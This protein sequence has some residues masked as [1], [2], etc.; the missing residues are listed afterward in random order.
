MTLLVDEIELDG[1]RVLNE[2]PSGTKNGVNT[3][4]GLANDFES[5]TLQL[6]VNG[7]RKTEGVGNDFVATESGGPGT[8]FDGFTLAFPPIADDNLLADYVKAL[9]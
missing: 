3:S 5:G 8:G 2:V 9:G 4:F 1:E 6:Y 7:V